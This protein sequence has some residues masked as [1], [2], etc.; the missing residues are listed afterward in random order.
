MEFL[1]KELDDYVVAHSG[2]EPELL[3]RLY[4]ETHLKMLM[5][6]MI[7]GP[8]QGRLL[9]MLAKM[10]QPKYILELGT[11][12]GYS[13]LCLAEG[14]ATDGEIHTIDKN[15]EREG[16]VQEFIKEAGYEKQIFQHIGNA[17][18]IIPI[19]E[20]DWDMVFID[21]DKENYL[22]YYELLIPKMKSGSYILADNMLWTGKV[23]DKN[24]NDLDTQILRK[25]NER[26]TADNRIENI[27]LPIRDGLQVGRI[28]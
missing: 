14:L 10:I 25:L 11:Y 8:F 6:R 20:Y 18:E 16:F 12:T 21:A 4:R 2:N 23:I 24:E 17:L 19:L 3:N 28:K 26:M 13:A 15:E 27:L 22:N 5:P 9:S 1:D 7:S